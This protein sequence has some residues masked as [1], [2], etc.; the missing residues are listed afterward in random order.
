MQHLGNPS[1]VTRRGGKQQLVLLDR[2]GP[3]YTIHGD[4]FDTI[5]VE[6]AVT[7]TAVLNLHLKASGHVLRVPEMLYAELWVEPPGTV[8][9]RICLGRFR[10]DYWNASFDE[11]ASEIT[12]HG[13]GPLGLIVDEA[14]HIVFAGELEQLVASLCAGSAPTDIDG[15]GTHP[16]N[17]YINMDSTYAALR[18]LGVSLGFVIKE[19]AQLF[20]IKIVGQGHERQRLES[21][22]MFEINDRN[23]LASTYTKGS[24]LRKRT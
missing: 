3:R 13:R 11:S 15:V 21:G 14:R 22:P 18:L 6:S 23:T 10:I 9:A 2:D 4:L 19:D 5:S 24:P 20:R 1:F 17:V 16:I 7:G 8:P 12:I